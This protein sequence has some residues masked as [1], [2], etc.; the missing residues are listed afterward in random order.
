MASFTLINCS[1]QTPTGSNHLCDYYVPGVPSNLGFSE[2]IRDYFPFEGNFQFRIKIST[3]KFN[4]VNNDTTKKSSF[5]WLDLACL[6][7]RD[8]LVDYLIDSN[9]GAIEI[10]VS[11]SQLFDN[12][13]SPC[14]TCGKT[15]PT[16]LFLCFCYETVF[17]I[18]CRVSF[19]SLIR[20][21]PFFR[22]CL[23]NRRL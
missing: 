17:F 5:Y 16:S 2:Q 1:L 13:G 9:A 20:L 10:Q 18:L 14:S 22:I 12:E 8:S 11:S 4:D 6:S 19:Y 21:S 23:C 15:F 3:K 7:P